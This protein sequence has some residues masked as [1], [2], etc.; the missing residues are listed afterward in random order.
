MGTKTNTLRR[1]IFSGTRLLIATLCI[2]SIFTTSAYAAFPGVNGNLVYSNILPSGDL[3]ISQIDIDNLDFNNPQSILTQDYGTSGIQQSMRFSADGNKIVFNNG[4]DQKDVYVINI[5]GTGLTNVSDLASRSLSVEHDAYG[6]S[7]ND[8]GTSIVY[9]ER[10]F[11]PDEFCSIFKVDTDGQNRTQLTATVA[12]QCDLL[13][14]YSPDGSKIAFVRHVDPDTLSKIM[15][16]NSDGTN[17]QELNQEFVSYG[18]SDPENAATV[19]TVID[20]SPVGN[21][22]IYTAP[23][24]DL[25]TLYIKTTDLSGNSTIL[26]TGVP[27][28]GDYS[29]G[30]LL[31]GPQFTPEGQVIFREI[32]FSNP[33]NVYQKI[34]NADGTSARILTTTDV[35]DLPSAYLFQHAH[36][37]VQP[38]PYPQLAGVS[39]GQTAEIRKVG[40]GA[41]T[42]K[43]IVSEN[44]LAAQDVT[45]DYPAGLVNFTLN[46][47]GNG[48]SA[49][50]T[51]LI[52]GISQDVS[53]YTARKFNSSNNTYTDIPDA[54]ITATTLDSQPAVEVKYTVTDGGVLDADGLVNGTI[55]DPVGLGVA[56]TASGNLASTGENTI[57]FQ[58]MALLGALLGLTYITHRVKY[59]L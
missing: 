43:N 12:G 32:L 25:S 29:E 41:I 9:S 2:F 40:C 56:A 24:M 1:T 31:L 48:G 30:S 57:A 39:G 38:L 17:V 46:D 45:R 28:N 49:E 51:L 47:C 37:S 8:S 6:G 26:Y 15:V 50:I 36:L 18:G 20:W 7:F 19:G 11:D 5:D 13:P 23:S 22:I 54:Q 44:S 34:M 52:T 42:S 35:S 55:V 27:I 14:V 16:M 53:L 3:A 58:M 33:T 4:T 59:A 21:K 10:W